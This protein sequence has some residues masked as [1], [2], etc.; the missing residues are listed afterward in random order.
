MVSPDPI[1]ARLFLKIHDEPIRN[2]RL[3]KRLAAHPGVVR[4]SL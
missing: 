3:R 4:A 2:P 1:V